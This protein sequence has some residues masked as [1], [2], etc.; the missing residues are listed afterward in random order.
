MSTEPEIEWNEDDPGGLTAVQTTI[1]GLEKANK[2]R[3]KNGY[4]PFL[5]LKP[6]TPEHLA[7]INEIRVRKGLHP[8]T[9]EDSVKM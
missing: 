1:E 5:I 2:H 4:R 3:I 9:A 8:L 7:E 6:H